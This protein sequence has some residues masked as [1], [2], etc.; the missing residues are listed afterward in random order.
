MAGLLDKLRG[1]KET[2]ARYCVGDVVDVKLRFE[3][4]TGVI[5]YIGPGL[6]FSPEEREVV[7][8][9]V[10]CNYPIAGGHDG[11]HGKVM[12][13]RYFV[14]RKDCGTFV[15]RDRIT[16]LRVKA[17]FAKH[18]KQTTKAESVKTVSEKGKARKGPTKKPF[19]KK[20]KSPFAKEAEGLRVTVND[21]VRL[22][23]H[24][25]GRVLFIG[26]IGDLKNYWFGIELSART[27]KHS[28]DIHDVQY[29][30]CKRDMHG[31]H[32]R[33]EE[34]VEVMSKSGEKPGHAAIRTA[35]LEKCATLKFELPPS[36]GTISMDTPR[37]DGDDHPSLLGPASADAEDGSDIYSD[38]DQEPAIRVSTIIPPDLDRKVSRA[39]ASVD[40]IQP[41]RKEVY[42]GE[43][44]SRRRKPRSATAG[45]PEEASLKAAKA[46]KRKFED[47]YEI[48]DDINNLLGFGS[49]ADVFVVYSKKRFLAGR[50]K[51]H[52]RKYA[53]KRM[54][55][56][57]MLKMSSRDR[58]VMLHRIRDELRHLK[59]LRRER[60]K[61]LPGYQNVVHFVEAFED[62]RFL[63]IVTNLC[64]G[65]T[66]YDW[67]ESKINP[68]EADLRFC[69]RQ[70]LLGL[71]FLS[72]YKIAHL[73]L[74]PNNI[75]IVKTKDGE[76]IFQIID[77]GMARVIP[78]L[79]SIS[80]DITG[81]PHFIA[82]EVI[83]GKYDPI[84]DM[85]SFGVILFM[86]AF[87]CPPFVD[88]EIAAG[89]DEIIFSKI[90]KGFDPTEKPGKGAW[91]P[92]DCRAKR[93]AYLKD[94]IAHLL[95][96]ATGRLT[97]DGA[98][99]HKWFSDT[100]LGAIGDESRSAAGTALS[101]SK[102][103][104]DSELSYEM[105]KALLTFSKQCKFRVLVSRMIAGA[106]NEDERARVTKT[107]A[108]FDSDGDGRISRDEFAAGMSKFKL[109]YTAMELRAIFD[110]VDVNG[111]HY[112]DLSEMMT[113]FA[114]QTL[115]ATDQRLEELFYELDVD[116]DGR[117]TREELELRIEELKEEEEALARRRAVM[118]DDGKK[119]KMLE[120]IERM[121]GGHT[122]MSEFI[123]K[124]LAS[125]DEN[126][127]G[128]ITKEE[129]MA[130]LHPDH[131]EA[132]VVDRFARDGPEMS[133]TATWTFMR[134]ATMTA[135]PDVRTPTFGRGD[136]E[137]LGYSSDDY[138]S[139]MDE[140]H[141]GELDDFYSSSEDY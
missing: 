14:S 51:K 102:S 116:G 10:E 141:G 108:E 56:A 19:W 80:G 138:S 30:E 85:W 65:G 127:D 64:N 95:V 53:M 104:G 50:T 81:T 22:R 128:G 121:T 90:K 54:K 99:D 88:P 62:H 59:H 96:P 31:I 124:A 20:T 39:E 126:L 67:L 52:R 58:K 40:G 125:V 73:D 61:E 134:M 92:K 115:A 86:C 87:G 113:A 105:H 120:S 35:I 84:A 63:Y 98:L 48:D 101:L 29:F 34:I 114:Y 122:T 136:E 15:T 132:S 66:L 130:S 16:N 74:N 36:K 131:R 97:I 91:F 25:W 7:F 89:R 129:F 83:D 93:S 68:S 118:S 76:E 4:V 17:K 46:E 9:G 5:K 110:A 107:F 71:K 8:Y 33:L 79:R 2:T 60:A 42:V 13:H 1:K 94:L 12:S 137:D 6:T 69:L 140:E 109:G 18:L 72:G 57:A 49:F 44:S 78:R 123:T 111:D 28:G 43:R 77:F 119:D 117:I 70:V 38:D 26:K 41:A 55:K 133:T 139:G 32:V 37:D 21:F 11:T 103:G 47:F 75:M 100:E 82:P 106:M 135:L 27:G 3:E 45:T 24:G 23:K 112:L